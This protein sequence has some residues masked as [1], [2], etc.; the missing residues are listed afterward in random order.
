MSSE[1]VIALFMPDGQLGTTAISRLR[2]EGL[3][4]ATGE[5]GPQVQVTLDCVLAEHIDYDSR[6]KP[7][8]TG[9]VDRVNIPPMASSTSESRHHG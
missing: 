5:N 8:G 3:K 9:N 2:A 1:R 6:P 7:R 4:V